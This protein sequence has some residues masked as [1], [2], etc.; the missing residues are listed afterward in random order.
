MLM[1][2]RLKLELALSTLRYRSG[3]IVADLICPRLPGERVK[4]HTSRHPLFA[5]LRHQAGI[6]GINITSYTSNCHPAQRDD[7][8]ITLPPRLIG[9]QGWL[10]VVSVLVVG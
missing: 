7:L 2:C 10:L 8:L 5:H 6:A 1:S 4:E 3:I 9:W